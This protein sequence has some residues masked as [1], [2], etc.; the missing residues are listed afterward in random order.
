MNRFVVFLISFTIAVFLTVAIKFVFI[1]ILGI[2]LGWY[3][4]KNRTEDYANFFGTSPKKV[5]DSRHSFV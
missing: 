1:P 2:P 5:F 3:N 4:P